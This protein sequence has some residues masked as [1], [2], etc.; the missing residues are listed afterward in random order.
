[1]NP[2]SGGPQ[3][4]PQAPMSPEG[5]LGGNSDWLRGAIGSIL[6]GLSQ[7]GVAAQNALHQLAA[8]LTGGQAPPNLPGNPNFDFLHRAPQI[9][10][11]PGM[12]PT[13]ERNTFQSP[14][15]LQQKVDAYMQEVAQ[16][17]KGKK[18]KK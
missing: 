12:A 8:F 16:R 11:T 7:G 6:G 17:N 2:T 5:Q 18:G 9:Q 10:A 3:A 13:P 15:Y 14:N 1:M 4:P